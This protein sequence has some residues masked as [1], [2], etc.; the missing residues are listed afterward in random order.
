MSARN[1]KWIGVPP[2]IENALSF[3]PDVVRHVVNAFS[4]VKGAT[5]DVGARMEVAH[6]LMEALLHL[7]CL[8]DEV[9]SALAKLPDDPNG[10]GSDIA[11]MVETLQ[12]R[13]PQ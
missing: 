8:E 10:N 9:R 4:C 2:D 1:A 12:S 11:G 5:D 6:Q 7:S 13:R 3:A